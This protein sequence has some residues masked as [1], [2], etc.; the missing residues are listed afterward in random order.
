VDRVVVVGAG[1]AGL[2]TVVALRAEGFAGALTLVGAESRPPYDRPPLSKAVL[3]GETDDPTLEAD[4]DG[5]GVDLRLGTRVTGLRP[6]AVSTLD[7]ELRY[8]GLV[9][10]SGALPVRPPG[11]AGARLLRTLE[12]AL[13]LRAALT[14]GIRVVV[15]GAGW[16]GAEVTTAAARAGCSVTV[17]EARSAPLA[18][19]LP[20]SVGM[21]T[22]S[23]YDEAGA[24]LRLGVGVDRMTPGA[25]HLADDEVLPADVVL[26]GVGVRPAT[27]W[28]AGSPVRRDARGAVL[29]DAALR[30]STPGIYAVGDCTAWLSGRY[31]ARLRVEHWDNALRA[32]GVAA[33][34]LLG[35][36][37]VY[38]PVPYFWSDQFGHTIQVAG[39]L[40]PSAGEPAVW[41]GDPA[42]GPP[43]T[44]CWLD[45]ASRADRL[46]AL[47][48]VDRPRDLLQGRRAIERA[49]AMDPLLLAEPDVP[50][51][52]A[53]RA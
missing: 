31:G 52:D 22:A 33:A 8:D 36:H 13:A 41:R 38:D 49:T 2:Q 12:D 53:L 15:V 16:I 19:A 25:V 37:A 3:R 32:P 1:L 7:G 5:L 44:A 20:A 28:L 26:A 11:F 23:W 45:R 27:G 18:A 9:I 24:R 50:I 48:T 42:A 4:W 17:V 47:V 40:E 21:C 6:G 34:N 51:R 14:A 35:G 46:V 39:W 30:T 29:V 43:W 10:A